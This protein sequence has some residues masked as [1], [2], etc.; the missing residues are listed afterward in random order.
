VR[1]A[2]LVALGGHT[3][4]RSGEGASVAAQRD[5]LRRSLGILAEIAGAGTR[6]AVV[7]G[8]GPQVG[9]ALIRSEAASGRSYPLPLDVCVAQTQGEI[10]YLI[11]ETLGDLLRERGSDR[12]VVTVITRTLV[13]PAG[14]EAGAPRKPIGPFYPSPPAASFPVAQDAG[15]GYRRT[16]PSPVPLEVLEAPVIRRLFEEGVVVVAAGGGGIAVRRTGEGSLAGVEAVVDKDWA[17]S[18]LA[19]A[20]GAGTVLDL[21]A[22][23][24]VKLGFGQAGERDLRRLTPAQAR[25]HLE[26]GEFHAG[27]MRPKI[28]AALHFVERGGGDVIITSPE[29][30][31][32]AIEGRA[33]TRIAAAADLRAE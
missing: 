8:N 12:R 25:R 23:D 28:E 24:C 13:D 20:L 7:H 4:L 26:E 14:L 18:L 22:V 11:Q 29:R 17:S 1:D 10:G 5:N 2:L 21:T 6:L 33:G 31:R 32:D 27:S 15:R 9:H 30:A 16:V 19:L 3:L